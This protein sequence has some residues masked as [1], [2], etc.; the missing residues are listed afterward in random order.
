MQE[1]EQ[2]Y[3]QQLLRTDRLEERNRGLLWLGVITLGMLWIAG[4]RFVSRLL[5]FVALSRHRPLPGW[6]A[7]FTAVAMPLY[8]WL[9]GLLS[10]A[11]HI[12]VLG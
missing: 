7:A 12:D 11:P 4:V 9:C 10:F 6:F 1:T 5:A 2:A 8:L 3:K